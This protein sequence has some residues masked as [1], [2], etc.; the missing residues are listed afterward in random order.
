[1]ATF[2][3]ILTWFVDEVGSFVWNFGIPV[4]EET[5][6]LV[7]IL[8]LGTGT[9]LTLRLGFIQ[10]RRLGHGF[11]VTSGKYDDP[12]EPGDVL[13]SIELSSRTGSGLDRLQRRLLHATF[14]QVGSPGSGS[15]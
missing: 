7:V 2:E 1:M 5:I 6:P 13:D 4:G 9:W 14:G 12:D 3:R 10:L 11:A 15:G 8:L